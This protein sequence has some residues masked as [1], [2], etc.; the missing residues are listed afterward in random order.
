M[1][2]PAISGIS[3]QWF[4]ADTTAGA[5]TA[6]GGGFTEGVKNIFSKIWQAVCELF[7]AIG[8]FFKTPPGMGLVAFLGF[9]GIGWILLAVAESTGMEGDGHKIGRIL[10]KIAAVAAFILSG[11]ALASGIIFGIV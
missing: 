4:L 6:S 1:T 5:E 2:A 9:A 11:A 7:N 10:L 8:E 3:P